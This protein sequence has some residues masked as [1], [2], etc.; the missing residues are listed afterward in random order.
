MVSCRSAAVAGSDL[1]VECR[2]VV[3]MHSGLLVIR[4]E[5]MVIGSYSPVML[6]YSVQNVKNH[7]IWQSEHLYA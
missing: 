6:L 4:R 5:D 1:L 2:D 3:V 7:N